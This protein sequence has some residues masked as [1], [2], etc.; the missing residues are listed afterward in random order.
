MLASLISKAVGCGGN[1]YMCV[2]VTAVPTDAK[3]HMIKPTNTAN[4]VVIA[5]HMRPANLRHKPL[6]KLCVRPQL[7]YKS[8]GHIPLPNAVVTREQLTDRTASGL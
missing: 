6:S 5:Q 7:P 3:T 1:V 4:N 8:Q 2:C